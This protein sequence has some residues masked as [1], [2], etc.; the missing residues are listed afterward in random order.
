MEATQF[1]SG[2]SCTKETAILAWQREER[3]SLD[4]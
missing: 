1:G 4:A 3:Q 2:G